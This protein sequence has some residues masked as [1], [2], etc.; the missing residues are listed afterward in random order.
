MFRF[1]QENVL[2]RR[3]LGKVRR[4][5]VLLWGGR[6]DDYLMTYQCRYGTD[7]DN[8]EIYRCISTTTTHKSLFNYCT[9]YWLWSRQNEEWVK[10][11][12]PTI[13]AALL[14]N[15]WLLWPMKGNWCDKKAIVIYSK[16]S[17]TQTVCTYCSD[18]CDQSSLILPSR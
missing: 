16:C 17:F 12:S 9:S 4:D 5:C 3:N 1:E 10:N 18:H 6:R 8:T 14:L 13:T 2:L 7:T 15:G 11:L